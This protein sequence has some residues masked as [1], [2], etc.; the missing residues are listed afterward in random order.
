MSGLKPTKLILNVTLIT[1]LPAGV[2]YLRTPAG[3][4]EEINTVET[5]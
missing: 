1:M 5:R 3:K 2:N 4:H